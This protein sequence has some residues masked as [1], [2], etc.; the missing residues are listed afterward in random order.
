MYKLHIPAPLEHARQAMM[1]AEKYFKSD[2][3]SG[4]HEAEI[5]RKNPMQLI[6]VTNVNDEVIAYTDAYLLT[7]EAYQALLKSEL[8]EHQFTAEHFLSMPEAIASPSIY[9]AG[10]AILDLD[11]PDRSVVRN[12]LLHGWLR[13]MRYYVA[14]RMVECSAIAYSQSG[15]NVMKRLGFSPGDKHAYGQI[16]QLALDKRAIDA[17]DNSLPPLDP[18]FTI[19]E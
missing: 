6:T 11:H 12:A 7:S 1:I 10:I 8:L 18:R 9:Y 13:L 14:D 2:H 19:V 16:Y 4:A 17:I 15:H 5:F 3:L